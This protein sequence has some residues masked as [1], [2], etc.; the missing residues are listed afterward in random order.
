MIDVFFDCLLTSFSSSCSHFDL[1]INKTI[2]LF[3][4]LFEVMINVS[5]YTVN[6][7]SLIIKKEYVQNTRLN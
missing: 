7:Y 6:L 1:I 5:D 2:S 3:S 4:G